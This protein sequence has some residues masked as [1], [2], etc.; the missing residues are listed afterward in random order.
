M[1]TSV[2]LVLLLAA[3]LAIAFFV[4][5]KPS[6]PMTEQ[7]AKRF[8]LEDLREKYPGADVREVMEILP[9]TAQDGTPYYQLKARVTNGM[10][11][12]C[13]ERIHVYYDY[14]QKNF[15]AQ[16]PEYITKGCKICI[17]E[18]NCIIAFPEE[19]IIASHTYPGAEAAAK[20]ITDHADAKAD[21]P[22]SLENYNG[23]SG[24]WLVR[25]SS[26]SSGTSYSVMVLKTQNK[27]VPSAPA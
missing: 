26:A 10:S 24:V 2:L 13:P 16:P 25:W 18:P 6:Y 22:S 21:A 11:T 7:D 8:F 20:F 4:F 1:K 19:A 12:P 14:P 27:V 17:N 15:V 3:A 9:L 23:Y 5:Y